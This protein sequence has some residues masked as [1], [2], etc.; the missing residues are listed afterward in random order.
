[1]L[2]AYDLCMRLSADST[3]PTSVGSP[4]LKKGISK[5][6]RTKIPTHFPHTKCKGITRFRKDH[7]S[8]A[9]GFDATRPR[10]SCGDAGL[11]V[12]DWH[13]I[14]LVPA[15]ASMAIVCNHKYT[16]RIK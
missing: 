5:Q 1:M 16:R 12:V 14:S 15:R 3:G 13:A 4:I 10:Q 8:T 6:I 9:G 7:S 2:R 11:K